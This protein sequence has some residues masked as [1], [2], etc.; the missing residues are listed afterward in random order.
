MFAPG[1][2]TFS[3]QQRRAQRKGAN[4]VARGGDL[5]RAGQR[6]RMLEIND[7]PY[8]GGARLLST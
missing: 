5:R 4:I 2:S 3:L 8:A 1:S 6:D 7:L